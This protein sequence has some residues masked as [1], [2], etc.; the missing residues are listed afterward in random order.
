MAGEAQQPVIP[1]VKGDQAVVWSGD[2][3]SVVEGND[4]GMRKLI[5]WIIMTNKPIDL[6]VKMISKPINETAYI[7]LTMTSKW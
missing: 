2:G 5:W 3:G 6:P 7:Y 4:N 1:V